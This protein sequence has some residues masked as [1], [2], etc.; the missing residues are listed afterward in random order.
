[1]TD[2]IVGGEKSIVGNVRSEEV[3]G[4]WRRTRGCV[5]RGSN[6][7]GNRRRMVNVDIVNIICWPVNLGYLVKI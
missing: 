2:S 3:K 6:M 5:G 1:M 7:V 4:R